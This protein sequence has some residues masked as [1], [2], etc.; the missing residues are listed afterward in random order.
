MTKSPFEFNDHSK[1]SRKRKQHLPPPPP[2]DGQ[3]PIPYLFW[4]MITL[5][6]EIERLKKAINLKNLAEK[7]QDKDGTQQLPFPKVLGKSLANREKD[8]SPIPEGTGTKVAWDEFY[9]W[10]DSQEND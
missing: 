2:K 4:N 7:P 3:D 9:L 5:A 10:L 8:S 6:N 1:S